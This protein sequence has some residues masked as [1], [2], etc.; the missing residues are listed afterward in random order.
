MAVMICYGLNV[1]VSAP[2]SYVEALIPSVF[3]GVA[4]MKYLDLD[5]DRRGWNSHDG[6][7]VCL[8]VSLSPPPL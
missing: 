7:S 6:I 1:C 8:S 3:G 2:N 4:F 5:E